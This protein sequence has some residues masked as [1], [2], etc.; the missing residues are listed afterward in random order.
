MEEENVLRRSQLEWDKDRKMMGVAENKLQPGLVLSM[1]AWVWFLVR[2][3]RYWDFFFEE[4]LSSNLEVGF[5][6]SC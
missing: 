2:A 4:L 1:W 3:Q 6:P 5:I